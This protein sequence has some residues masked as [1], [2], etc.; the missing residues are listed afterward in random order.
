[1]AFHSMRLISLSFIGKLEAEQVALSPPL[2]SLVFA[3]PGAALFF[4]FRQ[5]LTNRPPLK[6]GV[7]PCREIFTRRNGLR[8]PV[9]I[10]PTFSNLFGDV[11]GGFGNGYNGAVSVTRN[12]PGAPRTGA[13]PR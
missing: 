7:Y 2:P 11:P 6:P 5:L 10:T 1:M 9:Q 3:A 12:P 8:F 4:G 13:G